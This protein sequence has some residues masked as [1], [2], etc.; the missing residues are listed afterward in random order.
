M[1]YANTVNP[2]KIADLH[3]Y[4]GYCMQQHNERQ[5]QPSKTDLGEDEH[6][7]PPGMQLL[8]QPV[9]HLHLAALADLTAY[10]GRDVIDCVKDLTRT[11]QHLLIRSKQYLFAIELSKMD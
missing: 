6:L 3:E 11:I 8:E 1:G 2:E 9:E 10:K 5:H 7:V 4:I